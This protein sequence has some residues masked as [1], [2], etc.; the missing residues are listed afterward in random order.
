MQ[1]RT[2]EQRFGTPPGAKPTSQAVLIMIIA[3]VAAAAV[4]A[5]AGAAGM[6]LA[7]CTL[8]GCSKKCSRSI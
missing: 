2:R 8:L 4:A 7:S 5:G 3:I 6:L 1:Y